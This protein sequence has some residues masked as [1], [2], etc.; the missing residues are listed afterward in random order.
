MANVI[1]ATLYENLC[2]TFTVNKRVILSI[3]YDIEGQTQTDFL[4]Y[5]Q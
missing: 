1:D 5:L 2:A 3:L 4:D